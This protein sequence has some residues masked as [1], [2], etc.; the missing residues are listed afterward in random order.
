[1]TTYLGRKGQGYIQQIGYCQR[2][3]WKYLR[4]E[5]SEDQYIKGLL[6]CV[7]CVDPD[8][9]QRY[10][11]EPRA[12]GFP[13]LLPAP[14]QYPGPLAPT[15]AA[16]YT[17]V[18]EMDLSWTRAFDDA[19]LIEQ[20]LVYR[21]TNGG[22]AV[23]IAGVPYTDTYYFPNNQVEPIETGLSYSDDT[24]LPGNT[25]GYYLVA[26]AVDHRIS[27]NS[28]VVTIFTQPPSPILAGVYDYTHSAVD[29]S[30]SMPGSWGPSVNT[31]VIHRSVNGGAFSVLT[32]VTGTTT[33][34]VDSTAS[35]FT[36]IYE[37]YIV[38]TFTGVNSLLSNVVTAPVV[39]T[40]LYTVSTS[41][42]P[43][44]YPNAQRFAVVVVGG[45]AGGQSS[46]TL[47]SITAAGGNGGGAGG[48]SEATYT[49]TQIGSSPIVITVGLGGV[50]GAGIH[51]GPNSLTGQNLGANGLQSSFGALLVA[52]GGNATTGA[53]GS[54]TT[55]QGA[56]T[57]TL[58]G[59]GVGAR[60]GDSVN[61]P[62]NVG[63]SV[64]LAP[65]SGGGGGFPGPYDF[66]PGA[67]G[68]IGGSGQTSLVPSAGGAL[69]QAGANANTLSGYCGGGGGGGAKGGAIG[70]D[71]GH[72]GS[73]GAG[74]GGGGGG[75]SGTQSMYQGAGGAGAN[76]VVVV[77]IYS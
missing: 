55:Q 68:A 17:N 49:N 73:Y 27:P 23:L 58:A 53:G 56:G 31:Y 66:Q 41:F 35:T 54:G 19:D 75:F 20:Y 45:G 51:S 46:G 28:N 5:L 10:P 39:Q 4:T 1:M 29:L 7:Y 9:P 15:L 40:L 76:G 62:G 52:G 74:G 30:W 6:C 63:A 22:P 38:A 43:A 14:D 21:T 36:N 67:E 16:A 11:V 32:T 44:N 61:A 34:Y 42:A 8:Q 2:C 33:S 37:Y 64:T 48:L 69:S 70:N 59:S 24:V 77:T 60:V 57:N 72:G 13:P 25:Y 26:E 65:G 18:N 50:G 47:T 71:A 12:E 3:G